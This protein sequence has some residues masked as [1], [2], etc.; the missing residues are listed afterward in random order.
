MTT[1]AKLS[2]LEVFRQVCQQHGLKV[3]PQRTI[4]YTELLTSDDH[5]T[6][7]TIYSR[8]RQR[9]PNISFDTVYRTMATFRDIGLAH[10][11]DG[12]GTSMRFDPQTDQH[13]HFRCVRCQTIIDFTDPQYDELAVPEEIQRRCE[14]T[15]VR[16]TVEG[17]CDKCRRQPPEKA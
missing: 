3:T 2:S 14:V 17:L 6:L 13:H 11:V 9:S 1:N 10:A 15:G 8:V 4:I 7:E 16:V 12:F 5:P